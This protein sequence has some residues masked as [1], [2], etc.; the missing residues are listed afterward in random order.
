MFAK[1]EAE[2][3]ARFLLQRSQSFTEINPIIRLP[4]RL[5]KQT[6]KLAYVYCCIRYLYATCLLLISYIFFVFNSWLTHIR[7]E[8][9]VVHWDVQSMESLK[10]NKLLNVGRHQGILNVKYEMALAQ[11]ILC[12]TMYR[13]HFVFRML[14]DTISQALA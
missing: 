3:T 7:R 1:D 8:R 2:D 14:W 13:F 6:C 9:K 12:C 4:A 10:A 5:I 11:N